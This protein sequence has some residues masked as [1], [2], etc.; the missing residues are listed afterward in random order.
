MN[1]KK[2][3]RN[4]ELEEIIEEMDGPV[5]EALFLNKKTMHLA[6]LNIEEP[7]DTETY[8]LASD[9]WAVEPE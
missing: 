5:T 8:V 6:F 2:M 7:I 1:N 4:E 9:V 3:D